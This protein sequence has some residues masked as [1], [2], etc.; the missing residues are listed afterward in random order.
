MKVMQQKRIARAVISQRLR[1][2]IPYEEEV[3][4]ASFDI[5]QVATD[6]DIKA[7]SIWFADEAQRMANR[8][9]KKGSHVQTY[10]S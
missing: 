6:R 8:L 4:V 10:L 9:D 1:S 5:G 3:K 2:M 7:I